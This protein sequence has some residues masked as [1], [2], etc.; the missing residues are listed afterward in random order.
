MSNASTSS[1]LE[2]LARIWERLLQLPSV[3]TD[4][5]FFDLG[6]D[7]ALAV[8]LFSEIADSCGKQLPPVM[9]YHAPTITSLAALLEQRS[10]PKL[11]PLILL[12]DGSQKAPVFIAS[13]LGGGPA[14]FFQ[15]VKFIR[16]PNAVYGLQPRGIEGFDEP[17]E[18]IQ[19]MAAFYVK[20]VRRLQSQGPYILA[21]YSLGGLVTLEMARTLN[22]SGQKVALLVMID[23]YPDINALPPGQFLK[24]LTQRVKRR[25]TKF[26]QP[27]RTDIRL[28]G[29]SSPDAISTFAPAFERV[30]DA[31]YQALRRYKPTFY[32]GAVKFIR[33]AEVTDFPDDPKIVWSD[34]I[35]TLEVETAPGDHQGML[36]IH[37]EELAAVLNRYLE[38]AGSP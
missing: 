19:E 20:A 17:S 4:D 26:G 12:K 22:S 23:S 31:A 28:G 3:G 34:M 35:Q 38:K 30:R 10:T 13:G 5:N 27:P 6:G 14:E 32:P 24:L 25:V 15:L 2:V 33:A 21:G 37:Y 11:S 29:L 16:S 18:R 1:T 8:R 9:I 36:T 7:S